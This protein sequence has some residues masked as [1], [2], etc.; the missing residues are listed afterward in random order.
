MLSKVQLFDASKCDDLSTVYDCVGCSMYNTDDCVVA[1]AETAIELFKENEKLK[2]DLRG[3]D[4]EIEVLKW[5]VEHL[6]QFEP[7]DHKRQYDTFFIAIGDRD[8]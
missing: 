4:N 8:E 7:K 2:A 5:R 3:K 6:S 1:L